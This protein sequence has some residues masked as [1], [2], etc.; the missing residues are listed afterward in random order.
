MRANLKAARKAAERVQDGTSELSALARKA[1]S[2]AIR[3]GICPPSKRG[4]AYGYDGENFFVFW[5]CFEK[6]LLEYIND[7]TNNPG[8]MLNKQAQKKV[9]DRKHYR[10]LI[11]IS[12]STFCIGAI[13][14]AFLDSFGLG[15]FFFGLLLGGLG[16][17]LGKLC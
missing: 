16:F 14:S 11:L 3:A 7:N 1:M 4:K 9:A 2:A 15:V 12:I 17:G 10:D 6:D 5:S 8:K 13:L